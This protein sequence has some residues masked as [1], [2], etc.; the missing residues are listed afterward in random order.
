[1]K[2]YFTTPTVSEGPLAEGRLFSRFRLTKGVSV[3]KKDGEYT[4]IRFPSSEET[5]AADIFYL[6]GGTYEVSA[7]EAAD[8]QAAGYTITN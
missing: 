3:L 7:S 1:M 8:L 4:E 5:T 6:G 2:Y